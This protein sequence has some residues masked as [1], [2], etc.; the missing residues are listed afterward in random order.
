MPELPEVETIARFLASNIIGK[1]VNG[2]VVRRRDLRTVLQDDFEDLLIGRCIS[3]IERVAKYLILVLDNGMKVVFHL[4]MSGKLIHTQNS[5]ITKHQHIIFLLDD[6]SRLIF[7]DVR[8]FG[9]VRICD[10]ECYESLLEKIGP[11][12]LSSDFNAEYIM[13]TCSKMSIKGFLMDAASVAGI[14][15]IYASEIL[16]RAEILPSRKVS[17][18]SHTEC[19]RIVEATRYVLNLSISAGGSSI[20]DYKIPSGEKG[21]FQENFMVYGRGGKECYI[22]GAEVSAEKQDGRSTFFCIKCQK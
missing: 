12:P 13:R 3:G 5:E 6:G 17:T 22:C 16:F 18:L 14:G 21:R 20:K 19:A 11:D 15:N 9:S 2:V 1:F 8:R 7:D 4:G 10:G